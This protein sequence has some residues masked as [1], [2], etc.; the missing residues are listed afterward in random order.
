VA[1]SNMKS[2]ILQEDIRSELT[3]NYIFFSLQHQEPCNETMEE[4]QIKVF[5]PL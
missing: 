1:D 2:L 3:E 5:H 4:V